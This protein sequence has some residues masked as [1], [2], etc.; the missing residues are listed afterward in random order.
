MLKLA[1]CDDEK[2]QREEIV[3]IIVEALRL[4]NKQYKIFQFDN[5]ENLVS[6]TDVFDIYFLD[7]KMDKLTGLE[8]A[9]KIRLINKEAIIIFITGLKDYV[10]DA[11]D[12]NAFH[13]IL[14]PIDE[15]KLKDVLYSALLQFDKKDEFIIAKTISQATKIFLKDIMYIESQHRKLRIHTKNNI[16][17]YYHKISDIEKELYGCS[18]FRCHKSYI[19]NLKYVESYDNVFITL[20]NSEKIYVSKYRLD[21]FSKAFMYYLKNEVQ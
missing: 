8:V 3:G 13:Y 17:E 4:K 14:K 15:N 20:I 9:K 10:F 1:I 5:G 16:I 12:V 21:D 7:I 19:V 18:F 6:S 11:F 2:Y